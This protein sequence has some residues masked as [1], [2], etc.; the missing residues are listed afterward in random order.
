MPYK[1]TI[2]EC[3]EG[4]YKKGFEL[5]WQLVDGVVEIELSSLKRPWCFAR[6]GIEANIYRELSKY[7]PTV[8]L[9]WI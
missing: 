9:R 5:F 8:T 7:Y 4:S 6:E 2:R 1:P 3:I